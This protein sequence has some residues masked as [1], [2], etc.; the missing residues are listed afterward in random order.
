[1]PKLRRLLR[2]ALLLL[3]V[4][5]LPLSTASLQGQDLGDLLTATEYDST[6]LVPD[7]AGA[8]AIKRPPVF[9]DMQWAAQHDARWLLAGGS[10]A[11]GAYSRV[12]TATSAAA[13]V[14][15]DI[16]SSFQQILRAYS[17]YARMMEVYGQVKSMAKFLENYR[18]VVNVM[19]F[20]PQIVITD[21]GDPMLDEK[22][23]PA[24]SYVVGFMPKHN[25]AAWKNDAIMYKDNLYL[26]PQGG[27]TSGFA[28]G[29][30]NIIE[31]RYPSKWSDIKIDPSIW[32]GDES[33][34]E[35]AF[36]QRLMAGMYD[37][38]TSAGRFL[39][40]VGVDNNMESSVGRMSPRYFQQKEALAIERRIAALTRQRA[41]YDTALSNPSD[42]SVQAY[43]NLSPVDLIQAQ[44]NI[45]AEIV[46][47]QTK[48]STLLGVHTSRQVAW[49]QQGNFIQQI[50]AGLEAP[51]RRLTIARL[52]ER[53]KKYSNAW[54]NVGEGPDGTIEFMNAQPEITGNPQVD[55]AIY[56]IWQAITL[57]SAGQVPGP[58]P[59]S[60]GPAAEAQAALVKAMYRTL[61][62]EELVGI[63]RLLAGEH[64]YSTQTRGMKDVDA[65]KVD[66]SKH[67]AL[68]EADAVRI[69]KWAA[70]NDAKLQAANGQ[71]GAWLK[72]MMNQSTPN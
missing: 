67:I 55:N 29:G 47:L 5:L 27:S 6:L 20:V 8:F 24:R 2:M 30:M 21:P 28:I 4:A 46:S 68:I 17:E 41:L 32:G 43:S 7:V 60:G 12:T 61:T 33:D 38:V 39:S 65:M 49:V 16:G 59:V 62:Y 36:Q 44:K 18:L 25:A 70:I 37:G 14:F 56:L 58:V 57:L 72:P 69:Q 35:V 51:E 71:Y 48:K 23:P 34:G 9:S 10:H 26:D 64:Q 1:M 15:T 19:K 11:V 63:R 3:G 40:S 31:V 45:D 42:K 52:S 50:L 13:D 66:I 53:F 22:T 54:G